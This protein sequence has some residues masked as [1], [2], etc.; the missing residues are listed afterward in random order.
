M[1]E[2]LAAAQ[3]L[4]SPAPSPVGTC[5][6]GPSQSYALASGF[7]SVG[8]QSHML[9]VAAALQ[10]LIRDLVRGGMPEELAAAA[11]VQGSLMPQWRV[12]PWAPPPAA[13]CGVWLEVWY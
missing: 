9:L 2:T 1:P 11:S 4:S 5:I 6:L 10:R 3:Q 7:G 13:D 8:E 12:H